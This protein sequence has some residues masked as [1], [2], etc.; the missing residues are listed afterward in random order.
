MD[1]ML[2]MD[3][4]M[5]PDRVNLVQQVALAADAAAAIWPASANQVAIPGEKAFKSNVL[6]WGCVVHGTAPQRGLPVFPVRNG[7]DGG[8]QDHGILGGG[9]CPHHHGPANSG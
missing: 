8:P 4:V 1:S 2:E 3:H 6:P 5:D 9:H 7:E